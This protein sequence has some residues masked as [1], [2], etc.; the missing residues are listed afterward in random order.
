MKEKWNEWSR[1]QKIL[2][3]MMLAMTVAFGILTLVNRFR[4][5]IQFRDEFLCQKV[6]GEITVYS[7]RCDE[8][9][10]T[11]TAAKVG[12][13]TTL[14]F[15]TDIGWERHYTVTPWDG[16]APPVGSSF[17][18][19][20]GVEGVLVTEGEKEIF[21][22]AYEPDKGWLVGE[23]GE[24]SSEGFGF[25]IHAGYESLQQR[26][27]EYDPAAGTIVRLAWEPDVI[28][29]GNFGLY[30]LVV[31]L[32][33]IMAA[34]VAFPLFFF[35]LRHMFSVQNPEPTDFYLAM[36]KLEWGVMQVVL[37][38]AYWQAATVLP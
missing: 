14:D 4:P 13:N 21:R 11:I 26:W 3:A 16:F 6:E 2:L 32:T 34:D 35:Q 8:A 22:G 25:Y 19:R 33:A 20:K 28:H 7:G 12:E 15:T 10:L 27:E 18:A 5:G 29:R 38:V 31:L 30:L 24:L 37:L 9:E 17:F 36:Q 1:Y 23:D